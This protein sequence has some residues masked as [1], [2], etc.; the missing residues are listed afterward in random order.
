[1]DALA[2]DLAEGRISRRTAVRRFAA[3]AAGLAI[4]GALLAEPALARC[5]PSRKCGHKCCPHGARCKKGKC[6]CK[7]GLKK[8]GKKCLDVSSDAANCGSCGHVCPSG[9]T[10]VAGQCT[11]T[12]QCTTAADCPQGPAGDCQR[13]VC[14]NGTCGFVIDNTDLPSDSNPC[15]DDI[16][17]NGVP[18]HAFIA[19]GTPCPAGVCNGQGNCVGCNSAAD[20]PQGPA[21]DCQTAICVAGACGFAT[22]NNDPPAGDG[23]PCTQDI[24]V[25][26]VPSHVNAP[27]GT[28]CG[29]NL[30]CNSSGAC[31]GCNTAADCP[32]GPAGDCQKAV[33]NSGTCGFTVDNTDTPAASGECVTG[34]CS[35]GTPQQAPKS[36]GTACTENGG[37]VC[38]GTGTCGACVP[39][40]TRPCGGFTQVGIC[41]AGTET[42]LNDGSG[43][44]TCVGEGTPQPETCNGMDDDC[45]GQVDEGD[46]GAGS[47]CTC[48]TPDDG[49]TICAHQLGVCCSTNGTTCC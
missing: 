40:S 3:G 36:A 20:C 34:T 37:T 23:N 18:S 4:P 8:C 33:C 31:V 21:G 25:D 39:G 49:I 10:C 5:P 42:C 17:T 1:M 44:G 46:P 22:D 38:S 19:A 29:A 32:Q 14:A 11:G 26:G 30:V 35:A 7:G 16:C 6:K 2:K 45:D 43:Y 27:Q 9:Q 12:P 47:V 41:H 24:C 48:Q 28:S 15:T 13:A